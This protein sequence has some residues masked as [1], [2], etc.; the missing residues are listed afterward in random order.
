MA[1][2]SCLKSAG[3][4]APAGA[5]PSLAGMHLCCIYGSRDEHLD[6]AA[7]FIRQ[8]LELVEKVI[9]IADVM[10]AKS[11]LKILRE[12]GLKVYGRMSKGQLLI[13][14]SR[15]SYLRKG[16]FDPASMLDMLE[17]ETESALSGGYSAL[18]VLG[19]T[20]WALSG[21]PGAGRLLEYEERVNGFFPGRRCAALCL[22]DRK[23]FPPEMLL[24][25]LS[26]HAGV[27]MGKQ[28]YKNIFFSADGKPAGKRSPRKEL[29]YRLS[30]LKKTAGAV[31]QD[32]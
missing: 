28:V 11:F 32:S 13:L 27:M 25:I 2:Q 16:V 10:N 21:A 17:K 19:E 29:D 6:S 9:Y 30:M 15:G 31:L 24:K 1:G 5:A 26:A 22:Y 7:E 14:A 18:R 4:A 12:K 8:G 20:G 3:A 23:K